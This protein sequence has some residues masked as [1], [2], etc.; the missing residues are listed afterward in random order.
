MYK[1]KVW[2]KACIFDDYMEV[3]M[4]FGYEINKK[5]NDAYLYM[6]EKN[7]CILISRVE[8]KEESLQKQIYTIY[9]VIKSNRKN[10]SEPSIMKRNWKGT[11]QYMLRCSYGETK[12]IILT[13][14]CKDQKQYLVQFSY[15]GHHIDGWRKE[16]EYILNSIKFVK[17]KKEN[18]N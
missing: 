16:C 14:F 7:K 5:I 6:E 1:D 3:H 18:G 2:R 13:F 8:A 12:N 15:I 17:E 4:P 10:V 11:E 9:S